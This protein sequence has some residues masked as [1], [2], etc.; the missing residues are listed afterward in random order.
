MKQYKRAKGVSYRNYLKRISH[1]ADTRLLNLEKSTKY[2]IRNTPEFSQAYEY[3]Q[4]MTGNVSK[5]RF[6]RGLNKLSIK[7][8]KARIKQI[9]AFL[10]YETSTIRG[11]KQLSKKIDERLKEKLKNITGDESLT[12]MPSEF[13]RGYLDKQRAIDNDYVPYEE[14]LF[15]KYSKEEL[16]TMLDLSTSRVESAEKLYKKYGT[17]QYKR[18]LE[19][20]KKLK[21]YLE[22]NREVITS[23]ILP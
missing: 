1:V 4:K 3:A 8:V 12:E 13:Y 2:D 7:E 15:G 5:P 6:R 22:K 23:D 10:N 19:L 16:L 11:V 18:Q 20:E 9:E 21:E 17:K 14:E